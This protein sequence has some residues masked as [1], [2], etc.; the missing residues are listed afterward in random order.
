MT[1]N[2]FLSDIYISDLDMYLY[3][4]IH[5]RLEFMIGVVTLSWESTEYYDVTW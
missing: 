3:I 1:C 5:Y 4:R 2:G